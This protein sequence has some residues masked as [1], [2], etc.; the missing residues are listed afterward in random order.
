MI[1]HSAEFLGSASGSAG[2][3]RSGLP[4]VAF[5]GRSN[6]G[7]SS[8]I[9]S[10]LN[11]RRL[12]KTSVTP[13]KTRTINFFLVNGSFLF[14]DLPGYGYA[15]VSKNLQSSWKHMVERYLEGRPSLK[16]VVLLVDLR[17]P[18]KDLDR[19]M[20]AWLDHF[21]LPTV[22]V[23]TKADKVGGSARRESLS[24]IRRDLPVGAAQT[25]LPYSARTGL[26]RES[27]WEALKVSL[28]KNISSGGGADR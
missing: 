27:L 1:V 10:L 17:H 8:L 15:R 5:V 14:V 25:L 16:C 6:V 21:A 22:V 11:R 19:R 24:K 7:K 3:P 4:E 18:G 28:E 23:A 2:Y 20:K 12:A 9:N 13:G 26:G